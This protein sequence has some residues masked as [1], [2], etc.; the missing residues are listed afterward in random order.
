VVEPKSKFLFAAKLAFKL[1]LTTLNFY[2]E[3]QCGISINLFTATVH[4][5]R[6]LI[7]TTVLQYQKNQEQR[8]C[9]KFCVLKKKMWKDN[10]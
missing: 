9:F 5:N 8:I 7:L 1:A 2:A 10:S 3:F 6:A 4:I